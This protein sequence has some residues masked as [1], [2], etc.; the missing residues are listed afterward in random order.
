MTSFEF[1]VTENLSGVEGAIEGYF[2]VSDGI[3]AIGAAYD[4]NLRLEK[5]RQQNDSFIPIFTDEH[6][7]HSVLRILDQQYLERISGLVTFGSDRSTQNTHL[8]IM[9]REYRD[10]NRKFVAPLLKLPGK[11][12]NNSWNRNSPLLD[13]SFRFGSVAVLGNVCTI[14]VDES[15][16]ALSY[17]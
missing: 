14:S 2:V 3:G 10:L 7:L 4:C 8:A 1:E 11:E 9:A 16:P 12:S 6:H 5:N 13:L 15:I 17:Q